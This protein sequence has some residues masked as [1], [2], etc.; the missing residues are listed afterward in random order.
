MDIKHKAIND[1]IKRNELVVVIGTGVSIALTQNNKPELSWRGLIKNGYSHGKS[2]GKITDTQYES[3]QEFIDS[4]DMDELLL[5]AEFLGR[6]L[7]SPNGDLYARWLHNCFSEISPSNA[8]LQESLKKIAD[9]RVPICTLNYDTLTES[10]TSLP[11]SDIRITHELKD[12]STNKNSI[13]HL[14]G[15]WKKPDS[16]ILG[17][18]DYESTLDNPQRDLLQRA[19]G[20][21]KTFLFIGCN[22]TFSDPN[23]TALIGWTRHNFGANANMHYALTLE[24]EVSDKLKDGN[25]QGFVEPIS[26]GKNHNDLPAYLET[27]FGPSKVTDNQKNTTPAYSKTAIAEYKRILVKDCGQMTI[28]GVRADSDTAQ[29]RFDIEKL[30]VPLNVIALDKSNQKEDNPPQQR[31]SVH[32]AKAFGDIFKDNQHIALLA[33]PGGGKTLLLKRLA[34]AYADPERRALSNDDLPELDVTPILLKCREWREQIKLPIAKI[35]KNIPDILGSETLSG[36]GEAIKPLLKNGKILLLVDGLDE[37]HADADREIFVDNL[38]K[39]IDEYPKIRAVITSREAGFNLIAP[40]IS[41]FCSK[42]K[43]APLRTA[44]IVGLC[45]LWHQLMLSNDQE[46]TNEARQFSDRITSNGSLSRLA[47]NPLLLTMLLVVKHGAGRLPPDRVSLYE[48]AVEVLLDTW[49]IKG[50]DALSLK[51]A[52]PQ[53]AYIAFELMKSGKQ[54][55]TEKELLGILEEARELV[56][57]IKLYARD[58][59]YDFLKRVELRSSL[60]VEAGHQLESNKTVPFYQF[61]HLT[62][63]EYLA[64]VAVAEGNYKGYKK[65]EPIVTPLKKFIALDEWKEVIPMA[66]VLAGKQAHTLIEELITQANKLEVKVREKSKVAAVKDWTH[67]GGALPAPVSRLIQCLIEEAQ[68]GPESITPALRTTAFFAKGGSS[69]IDWK[70]LCRGPYAK[71]L[72]NQAWELF[73]DEDTPRDTWINNTCAL[74]LGPDNEIEELSVK[75][76]E[77]DLLPLLDSPDVEIV[78]KGLFKLIGILWR[79]TPIMKDDA[80]L[81]TPDLAE[82][83]ERFVFSEDKHVRFLATWLWGLGSLE[84]EYSTPRI[85]Q[86]LDRFLEGWTSDHQVDFD[87]TVYGFAFAS[88]TG[89][90]RMEWTPKLS[91]STKRVL[92]EKVKLA[93]NSESKMYAHIAQLSIAYYSGDL[94][95]EASLRRGITKA[96]KEKRIYKTAIPTSNIRDPLK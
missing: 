30:F 22:G 76:I 54:T 73:I 75:E 28:E 39:F 16:C 94:I 85:S 41:E 36:F 87:K 53:L 92:L 69:S 52:I 55:A 57:Q 43:L 95:S 42:W 70:A 50:H 32:K 88:T 79:A 58:T 34:A 13:L 93:K 29:R 78:C 8:Q 66:A 63:Q 90:S 19:L 49:N 12:W 3:W 5:S 46:A 14:H 65:N 77:K 27:L 56:P 26:Y 33:L 6:K 23:L 96:I 21:F 82:R 62:F 18:R 2:I 64:A 10:C 40:R 24:D 74:L 4:D 67:Y 38:R 59:P 7:G 47:E 9:L 35:L 25:W 20:V 48:R 17:V 71:A 89:I 11:S 61:R 86:V 45:T 91:E 81:I 1:A 15:I 68:I 31:A 72:Y 60:L 84:S 37:I 83:L 80:K 44:E 51:E